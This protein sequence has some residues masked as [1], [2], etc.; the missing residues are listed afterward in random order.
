VSAAWALKELMP[1]AELWDVLPPRQNGAN[2]LE[3]ILRFA[4][5][6]RD[7]VAIARS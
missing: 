2:V 1:R 4:S 3:Q 7:K 6:Q 5:P